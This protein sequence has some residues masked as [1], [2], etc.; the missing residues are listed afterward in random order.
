[1]KKSIWIRILTVCLAA[2]LIVGAT[3][4]S[5][6]FDLSGDG[7]TNVWD[8]QMAK[9]QEM[10]AEEQERALREALNGGDELHKPVGDL[11]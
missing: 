4:A 8:L 6:T 7:T 1:M 3:A 9:N 11:V 2:A 10:S 5:L